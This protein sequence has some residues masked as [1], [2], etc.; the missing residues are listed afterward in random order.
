[1]SNAHDRLKAAEDAW[2][3]ELERLYGPHAACTRHEPCAAGVP[4]TELH[5]LHGE[6]VRRLG[7]TLTAMRDQTRTESG[8]VYAGKFALDVMVLTAGAGAAL[9]FWIGTP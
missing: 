9:W 8:L 7:E 1:M 6:Y 2:L 5:R 4:G 3:A